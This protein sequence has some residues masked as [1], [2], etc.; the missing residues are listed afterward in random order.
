MRTL[1][2]LAALLLAPSLASAEVPL[3]SY[4]K[5]L[6]IAAW[7]RVN[8][9]IDRGRRLQSQQ[10][11]QLSPENQAE[12]KREAEAAFRAAIDEAE[13]FRTTV[14]DTSGVA[15]LEG[16]AWRYLEQPTR[17]EAAWRRSIDLDPAGAVDA[18]H[19]LGELMLPRQQWDEADA[20]FAKV[21]EHLTTGQEAWRGPLRQAEVAAWKGDAERME[22]HLHEA[23]RRG[24][25]LNFI[26]HQPQWRTF[27]AD[28][29]LHDTV[30][31]MVL[32]YGD[33]SLLPVLGAP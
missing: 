16:L 31:K 25:N 4:E 13:A 24:F 6:G 23:L 19:D 5:R 22:Q 14:T 28:P 27:Y 11:P 12:L 7:Y 20:C 32:V 9:H 26:R 1:S 18:W 29:R 21:T 10:S 15:Y 30:E 3:P 2:L 17:A 8:E 33:R